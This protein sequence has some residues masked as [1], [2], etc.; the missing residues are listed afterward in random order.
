MYDLLIGFLL[1][2]FNLPSIAKQSQSVWPDLTVI[3]SMSGELAQYDK[4]L[5]TLVRRIEMGSLSLG[6]QPTRVI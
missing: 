4:V 6:Q 5:L 3:G 2:M 1:L